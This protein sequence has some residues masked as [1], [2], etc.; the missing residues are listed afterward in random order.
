[1]EEEQELL[2]ICL[3]HELCFQELFFPPLL[4]QL[5]LLSKRHSFF[6]VV[7]LLSMI[8]GFPQEHLVGSLNFFS[9]CKTDITVPQEGH[10]NLALTTWGLTSLACLTNPSK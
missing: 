10:S 8:Q 5:N 4:A 3:K 7:L 6:L 9:I 1:M 2:L